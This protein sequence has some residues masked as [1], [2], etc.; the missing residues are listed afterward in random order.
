MLLAPVP[1]EHIVAIV[2][3]V[4]VGALDPFRFVVL[5]HMTKKVPGATNQFLADLAAAE[6]SFI[7]IGDC[8]LGGD[9]ILSGIVA[10]T[11]QI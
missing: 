4:A 11:R 9:C 6:R 1:S 10:W 3:L 5:L 7:L 2:P 8:I